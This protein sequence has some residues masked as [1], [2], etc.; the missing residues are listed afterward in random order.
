MTIGLASVIILILWISIQTNFDKFHKDRDQL[1]KVGMIVRTPNREFND[2]TINAPAGPEYKRAFRQWSKWSDLIHV[3]NLSCTTTDLQGSGF[4]I[5]TVHS[6]T[7]SLLAWQR[8][9]N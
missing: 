9:I 5:L 3:T 1:Y 4:S 2:A 6:L 8:V 7:C